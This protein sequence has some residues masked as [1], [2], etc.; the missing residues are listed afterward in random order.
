MKTLIRV[1]L[2][3]LFPVA[4]LRYRAY[5]SLIGDQGSY[6]YSS[7]WMQSLRERRPIDNNENLIPWMN[8]PVVKLLEERLTRELDLFE[9]G[10]GYSTLFY[11]S[12]VKTVTSLE[13]DEVWFADIKARAPANVRL[14]LQRNDVDGDYCRV[15][16]STGDRYDVVVVDG[17]DRVNCVKHS[18]SALSPRG[19]IVL[20]DSNRESYGEGIEFARKSGFKALSLEGLKAKGGG[21]YRTTILYRQENCLDI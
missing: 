17:R 14:I 19:V 20:D 2:E 5:R 3:R 4:A 13:Y 8:F 21:S 16:A 18:V 12:R 10:S 11:A 15:I 6:L 9:F 7:G 1:G